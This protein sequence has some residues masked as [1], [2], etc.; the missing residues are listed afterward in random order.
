MSL[1]TQKEQ[2]ET[3]NRRLYP[4]GTSRGVVL[5][6]F[7]L[8]RWGRLINISEGGMAFEFYQLPPSDQRIS[9]ALEAMGLESP[10]PSGELAT[11]S[12]H[13][14]GQV[15]W[16][17]DFERCAGVQFVDISADTRQQIRQWLFIEDFSGAAAEGGKVERDAVETE[18]PERPLTLQDT[19]SQ[20]TNEGQLWNAESAQSSSPKVPWGSEV[21]EQPR[22]EERTGAKSQITDR[23]ALM[24]MARWLAVLALL[25]GITTIILW[26][27]VHLAA[28]FESIRQPSIGNSA[29]RRAGERSLARNKLLF[30]VEA[31]D[32]NNRR[33]LLTFDNDASAVH[34]WLSS[35]TAASRTPHRPF[36]T[37]AAS[38]SAER[39][40]EEKRRS[41][42]NPKL[43]RPSA[44]RAATN[45]SP[46]DP[47]LAVDLGAASREPIGAMHPSG[48]ILAKS[49]QQVSAAPRIPLGGKVQQARLIS[50]VSP[51]YPAFARSIGLQ[52][53]IT[54]DA[55][56]DSTGKVTTMKLLS[57]PVP[58][59]QAAMDA[60]RQWKYE[61]AQ[62]DSQPVSTHLSVTIKFRLH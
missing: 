59:Q 42:S 3:D 40:N 50:S 30:Q 48:G 12:I 21:N 49:T 33:R 23:A 27:R 14:D 17:R 46:E 29:L 51:A 39:T 53:D 5:V 19:T 25:G 9:F 52:G 55:L 37:N 11:D 38:P 43:S 32:A 28:L 20:G 35:D 58:L 41:L 31:V 1:T 47:M 24:S 22:L 10:E 44:T 60:L 36:S 8:G 56:I 2:V 61:P 57:G 16:T 4:R 34:A 26:Q 54:I 45:A 13:A 18:L 62:L 7:G 15:V 6:F